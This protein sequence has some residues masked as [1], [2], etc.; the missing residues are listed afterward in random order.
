MASASWHGV[1]LA[2]T[3]DT[4]VVEDSHYFPPD[5]I[6][7][8][9]FQ[10]SPTHSLCPWKGRA[11]YYTVVVDGAENADAA[12]T[13]PAQLPAAESIRDHVAFWHGVEVSP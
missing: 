6:R 4:V 10:P 1:T 11:S 2:D 3:P 13:Y 12:W 7:W 8:E 5:S 9:H